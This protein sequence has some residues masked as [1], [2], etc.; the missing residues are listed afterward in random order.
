[1]ND[2]A[3]IVKTANFVQILCLRRS[4]KG[5]IV[6]LFLAIASMLMLSCSHGSYIKIEGYAQGGTYSVTFNMEGVDL[7]PVEIRDSIEAILHM[8][9]FTLSGYNRNSLLSRF[10]AGGNVLV[11]EMFADIYSHADAIC[12][13][14]DG[15]GTANRHR[16]VYS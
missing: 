16:A 2:S 7:S 3:N 12:K 6:I 5:K 11:N 4:M 13:E 10:N 1:M 8:I 14:T 9:D 15:G